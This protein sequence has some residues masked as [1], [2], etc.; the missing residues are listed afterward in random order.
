VLLEGQDCGRDES[1]N[2]SYDTGVVDTY[3]EVCISFSFSS[4]ISA[5]IIRGMAG[6]DTYLIVGQTYLE[7]IQ[8]LAWWQSL[9][10]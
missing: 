1:S 4:R 8:W 5:L 2:Q 9:F 6:E 7:M 3:G 10:P